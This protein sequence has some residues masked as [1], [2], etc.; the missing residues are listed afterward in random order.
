MYVRIM[1]TM[2]NGGYRSGFFKK[3]NYMGKMQLHR[4]SNMFTCLIYKFYLSLFKIYCREK[5]L[6]EVKCTVGIE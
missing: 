4:L 1:T 3:Q 5:N 2:G 6:Q